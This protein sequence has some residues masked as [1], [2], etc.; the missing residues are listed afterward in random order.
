MEKLMGRRVVAASVLP[1]QRGSNPATTGLP[2]QWN[3]TS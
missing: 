2:R 1:L 3:E